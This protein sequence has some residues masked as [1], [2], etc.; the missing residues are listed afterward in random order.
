MSRYQHHGQSRGTGQGRYEQLRGSSNGGLIAAT[1]LLGAL[2]FVSVILTVTAWVGRSEERSRANKLQ[3][4]LDAVKHIKVQ[5][6]RKVHHDDVRSQT[7]LAP[8]CPRCPQLNRELQ[9]ALAEL[10]NAYD[11]MTDKQKDEIYYT[12][13]IVPRNVT[14]VDVVDPTKPSVNLLQ[15]SFSV[16]NQSAQPRG[17]TMGL[18][19]LY[20]AQQQ[21]W[22][23]KFTVPTLRKDESA[24]IRFLAPGNMKWD[25][26][27]C[28]IYSSTPTGVDGLPQQQ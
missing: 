22:Q 3:V 15:I 17:N 2:L 25:G 26:W 12:Y 5:D 24:N 6:E 1:L 11:K 8:G 4:E 16:K 21:I 7:G 27:F 18:F 13:D 19:K 10:R 9:G 28:N 14:L 20:D 23:K